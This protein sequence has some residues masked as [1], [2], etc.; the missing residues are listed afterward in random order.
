MKTSLINNYISLSGDISF[1]LRTFCLCSILPTESTY[2]SHLKY[3]LSR[4][5]KMF[6]LGGKDDRP[7]LQSFSSAFAHTFLSVNKSHRYILSYRVYANAVL[8]YSF[9]N[10]HIFCHPPIPSR[11][12]DTIF[13]TFVSSGLWAFCLQK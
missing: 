8:F 2:L 7:P 5:P 10:I 9:Y 1:C 6:C 4:Q 13:Q 11:Q 12:N 3:R